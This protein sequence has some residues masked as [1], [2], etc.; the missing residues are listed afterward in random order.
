MYVLVPARIEY[1]HVF[2][3]PQR[4]RDRPRYTG[5]LGVTGTW[6]EEYVAMMVIGYTRFCMRDQCTV[7]LS[8]FLGAQNERNEPHV[9]ELSPSSWSS[10]QV[11][12]EICLGKLGDFIAHEWTCKLCLYGDWNDYK[13]CVCI[14]NKGNR[15]NYDS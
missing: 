6:T 9:L 13:N 11:A 1:P 8:D 12:S 15:V 7:R 2:L 4:T 5:C 10:V 3:A 14:I